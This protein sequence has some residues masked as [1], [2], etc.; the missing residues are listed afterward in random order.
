MGVPERKV[1]K[2]TNITNMHIVFI[3]MH[4][5]NKRISPLFKRNNESEEINKQRT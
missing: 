1:I 5:E 2:P 4:P 3:Q